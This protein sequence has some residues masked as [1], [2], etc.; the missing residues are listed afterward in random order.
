MGDKTLLEYIPFTS[1]IN[2]S[3]WSKLTEI[4]LDVDKLEE[5][6]R[7]IWGYVSMVGSQAQMLLEVDST[8]F[9]T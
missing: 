1:S 7:K 8:S 4:K 3:F 6:Q 5:N 9:N 2:P